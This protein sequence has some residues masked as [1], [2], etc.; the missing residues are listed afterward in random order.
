MTE[1]LKPPE[2]PWTL[3]PPTV[4]TRAMLVY[5]AS[6]W[7]GR[8]APGHPNEMCT[9]FPTMPYAICWSPER[10]LATSAAASSVVASLA[11]MRSAH[12]PGPGTVCGAR[13]LGV[14]AP[15]APGVPEAP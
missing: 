14:A 1:G 11:S 13:A 2:C 9:V 4:P 15:Q 7:G 8:S 12:D 5:T 3:R 6:G 10:A